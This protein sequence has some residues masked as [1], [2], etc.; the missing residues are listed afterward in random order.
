MSLFAYNSSRCLGESI[1]IKT[2][3]CQLVST[4][5]VYAKFENDVFNVT[6]YSD[7]I[8]KKNLTNPLVS[9]L[10]I[11]NACYGYPDVNLG[12]S[13]S[14]NYGHHSKGTVN[15]PQLLLIFIIV[16]TSITIYFI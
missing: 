7:S 15:K 10:I 3:T 5:F 14:E 16:F 4:N 1:L 8:C 9:K 11:D 6:V 12:F 2:N 13:K